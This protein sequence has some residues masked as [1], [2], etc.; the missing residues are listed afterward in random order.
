M[1][2]PICLLTNCVLIIFCAFRPEPSTSKSSEM[3]GRK[4]APMYLK[5]YER[6]LILE[7]GGY[8]HTVFVGISG[9]VYSAC[10]S[11]VPQF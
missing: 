8:V 2:C 1:I 3:K 7:K 6:K 11:F 5:D 10:A 9:G 4:N